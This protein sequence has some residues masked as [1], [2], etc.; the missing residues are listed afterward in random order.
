MPFA[1]AIRRQPLQSSGLRMVY[2]SQNC[3]CRFSSRKAVIVQLYG[4]GDARARATSA[5]MAD[6]TVLWQVYQ[7][8]F[9]DVTLLIVDKKCRSKT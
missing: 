3:L 7:F 8:I 4:Q 1:A 6:Y 9:W 2:R 5:P